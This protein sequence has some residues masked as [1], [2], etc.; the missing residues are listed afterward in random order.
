M[1]MATWISK[2]PALRTIPE[3]SGSG[4]LFAALPGLNFHGAQFLPEAETAGAAA[5]LTN[6]EVQTDLPRIYVDIPR[7]SL[8]ASE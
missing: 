8:A 1:P 4:Y 6:L 7:R 3:R 2:F 5:I